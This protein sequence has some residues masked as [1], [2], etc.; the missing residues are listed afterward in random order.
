MAATAEP[1]PVDAAALVDLG[2]G[3]FVMKAASLGAG[4]EI[5]DRLAGGPESSEAL[6]AASGADPVALRRLLRVLGASGLLTEAEPGRFG[7]SARG[8]LL[9]GDVPGSLKNF[10]R[11][12]DGLFVPL[13]PQAMHSIRTGE[14]VFERVFGVPFFDFLAKEPELGTVFSESMQDLSRQ[15]IPP[16]VEAYDFSPIGTLVDVGGGHGSLLRAVL[17]AHP[18]LRG[19][20]FDLPPVIDRARELLAASEVADRCD[21]VGGDFFETVPA[22]GDAY[23]LSWIIHDWDE[24]RALRILENCRAAMADDGRLLLVEAV[25]PAGNEPH[26]GWILDLVMLMGLGGRERDESE[27]G[28]LLARAGFRMTRVVR[29]PSPMSIV[30]AR[31]A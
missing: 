9:R 5:F 4:L 21:V 20:L 26:F 12:L 14:P 28:D 25:L 29:S 31:P 30:E 6:A 2:A 17:T 3:I 11:M 22:G 16:V 23:I 15:F 10:F 7:L 8:E 27:Y 1:G 13:L 24:P 18:G 19:V